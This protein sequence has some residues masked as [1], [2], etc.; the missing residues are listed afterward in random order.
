MSVK[1][2]QK[3]EA[4]EFHSLS[5]HSTFFTQPDV[6]EVIFDQVEWWGF[7]KGEQLICIWPI[8][9]N[10]KREPVMNYYF[11]YY[12]GPLWAASLPDNPAHRSISVCTAVYNAMYDAFANN[13]PA[14]T[15]TF[16]PKLNDIRPFIWRNQNIELEKHSFN[17]KYTAILRLGDVNLILNNFRQARRRQLKDASLNN[18][19]FKFN[20]FDIDDIV[21]FYSESIPPYGGSKNQPFDLIQMLRRYLSLKVSQGINSIRVTELSSGKTVAFYLVGL[22]KEVVNIIMNNVSKTY[23]DNGSYLTA[24]LN[25]LVIKKFTEAGFKIL[26][27]NGANSLLLADDKHSYGASAIPYYNIKSIFGSIQ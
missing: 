25:F 24:Y 15:S 26:D 22:H 11:T 27:F 6:L 17:I 18:L 16:N 3:S 9:L 14:I 13:Y 8:V 23:K 5:Q 4:Y 10:H 20:D 21:E 7:F 2:I 12:V 19:E 1:R